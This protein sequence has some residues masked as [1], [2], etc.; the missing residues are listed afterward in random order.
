M[1]TPVE[2]G[3]GESYFGKPMY[4]KGLRAGVEQASFDEALTPAEF[5]AKK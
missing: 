4:V 5:F 3:E 2:A 1:L